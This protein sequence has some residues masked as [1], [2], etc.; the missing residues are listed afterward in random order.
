MSQKV[1]RVV[2]RAINTGSKSERRDAIMLEADDATY[3]LRR[4]GG[5]PFADDPTLD[6]LVGKLIDAKGRQ[7]GST[8]LMDDW[9]ERKD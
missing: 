6:R 3:V 5:N 9:S 1:G 2:R 8:F 7:H 4:R